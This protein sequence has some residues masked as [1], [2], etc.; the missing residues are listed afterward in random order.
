MQVPL[1]PRTTGRRTPG[2]RC[3]LRHPGKEAG[4]PRSRRIGHKTIEVSGLSR[5][6]PDS[7]WTV[8]RF[9]PPLPT[10]LGPRSGPNLRVPAVVER[11]VAAWARARVL[12][13]AVSSVVRSRAHRL[14]SGSLLL[15]EYQGRRSGQ[16]HVLPVM[17]AADGED[18]I[19]VA[20]GHRSERWWRNFGS[21]PRSVT[22][23]VRRQHR[24][25]SAR[26]RTSDADGRGEAL[27]THRRRFLKAALD[28]D[29]PVVLLVGP[30][31][32]KC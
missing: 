27:G 28:P 10:C 32:E 18:L 4:Q 8:T 5:Q 16:R 25:V 21:A 17:Y 22:V 20:G 1:T 12:N 23:T 2:R 31:S 7:V 26:K 13:R 29:A 9:A 14:L 11:S 3:V 6:H 24:P 30:R 19:V 15:L